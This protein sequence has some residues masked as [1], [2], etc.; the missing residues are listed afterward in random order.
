MER[1]GSELGGGRKGSE[2]EA[3]IPECSIVVYN[4]SHSAGH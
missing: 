3:H 1:K 4:T 2:P